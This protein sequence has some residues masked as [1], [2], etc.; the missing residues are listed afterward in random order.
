MK[1]QLRIVVLGSAI[2]L[3][4]LA[5][6]S[7]I[8]DEFQ[9][10]SLIPRGVDGYA[11]V[12]MKD[13]CLRAPLNTFVYRIETSDSNSTILKVSNLVNKILSENADVVCVQE[14]VADSSVY[15][16]CEALQQSYAHFLYIPSIAELDSA[17]E[18][19][20]IGTLIASKYHMEQPQLGEASIK[21]INLYPDSSD[22]H[23]LLWKPSLYSRGKQE[24]AI[25]LIKSRRDRDDDAGGS[26][27]TGIRATWGD[28]IHWEGYVRGEAHDDR[29]N[30]VEGELKQR[31]DGTGGVDIRGGHE[32]QD[33]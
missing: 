32:K 13:V 28:G 31:D 14:I 16:L 23:S 18:V 4:Q 17:K 21:I 15:D 27:E 24:C 2:L 26:C 30:Y 29:G 19:S 6:K 12:L 22:N 33:K 25:L 20:E 5:P 11:D 8:A 3:S 10:S 7:L 9:E 1:S